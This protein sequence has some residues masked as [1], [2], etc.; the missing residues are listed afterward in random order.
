MLTLITLTV[1]STENSVAQRDD[2]SE[3]GQDFHLR[4]VSKPHDPDPTKQ[5]DEERTQML[6][7]HIREARALLKAGNHRKFFQDHVD[8]FWVARA[9]ASMNVQVDEFLKKMLDEN[10]DRR[11]AMT[12]RFAQTLDEI[13]NQ[14]PMFLL[15][16]RAASFMKNRSSLTA[17]FWV[18][19]DGRWRMSPE[20]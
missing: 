13:R 4:S 10:P 18:Y 2:S 7:K 6:R 16:G 1:V 5:S 17:E 15:N 19:F 12:E 3:S 20:T 8:P 14:E 11:N 9:A